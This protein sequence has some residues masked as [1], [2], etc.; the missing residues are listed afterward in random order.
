METDPL[1]SVSGNL[2]DLQRFSINDGPGIRTLVFFKG[3]PLRCEWCAN[4]ESQRPEPELFYSPARCL[5][6]GFCARDCPEG[7]LQVRATRVA[8]DRR[9]CT[10]CGDCAAACPAGAMRLV[11]RWMS[12]PQVMAEVERDAVFY[13]HSGGGMT[14][15]GGEPLN[16]PEFAVALLRAARAAGIH[17]AVETCGWSTP[18][19]VK[20]VLGETDLILYDLK[21]T[22]STIHRLHTGKP[23]ERILE[24]ARVAAGLGVRMIV[25]VPVIPGFNDRVADITEIG[26]ATRALGVSELHLLPYHRFGAAKYE[27]L[28]REYGLAGVESPAQAR[29]EELRAELERIGLKAQVGG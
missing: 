5:N 12:V 14:L 23:N 13:A 11:G 8:L 20:R 26:K 1:P 21:Q 28:G 24:N 17:T 3:C 2:F 10:I 9:R 16:Q 4:P 18:G 22:N 7:A 6:C 27:Q 19:T 15:S 29:V 25:R